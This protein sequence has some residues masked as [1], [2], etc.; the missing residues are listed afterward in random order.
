MFA[1]VQRLRDRPALDL[2]AYKW[3]RHRHY[4]LRDYR[5]LF[6][7]T[8]MAGGYRIDRVRRSGLLVFPLALNITFYASMVP[9][10]IRDR[11]LRPVHWLSGVEYWVPFGPLAYNLGVRILKA[12]R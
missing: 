5:R 11:L 2:A 7:S 10:S 3:K 6:D 12:P 9:A 4:T 8:S 1:K